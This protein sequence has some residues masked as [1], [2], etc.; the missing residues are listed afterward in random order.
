MEDTA[1]DLGHK[2]GRAVPTSCEAHCTEAGEAPR[3]N[4]EHGMVFFP[5][6]DI[7]CLILIAMR[8]SSHNFGSEAPTVRHGPGSV[9]ECWGG[10]VQVGDSCQGP[11]RAGRSLRQHEPLFQSMLC[12]RER[13]GCN[14]PGPLVTGR[15]RL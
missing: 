7:F 15:T 6:L 9:G 14:A 4:L 11:S 5:D 1:L 10:S 2:R 8:G 12:S 3:A 13:S